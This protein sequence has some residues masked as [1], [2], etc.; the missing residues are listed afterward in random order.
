ML[1]VDGGGEETVTLTRAD[2]L[3]VYQ[4]GINRWRAGRDNDGG[5]VLFEVGTP[6]IFLS[7]GICDD[8]SFERAVLDFYPTI[9]C[10][11]YDPISD[12]GAVKHPRLRFHQENVPLPG[13]IAAGKN[14]LVKLDIEGDE[15]PW[16]WSLA[17]PDAIA[18]LV[19]ELHSPHLER[20]NWDVLRDLTK[21]HALVHFHANN[22]DGIVDIDGV[23]VPGTMETTW[24]RRDLAGNLEPNREPI[25]GFLD[26]PNDKSKPD[27][28]IDW[29]P[30]FG[31]TP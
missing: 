13:E 8:N 15:W 3:R 19:V 11:A 27:H 30:F 4:C 9:E 24:V 25:P 2:F 31:W 16:L 29:A 22:W 10:D 12:G 23:R 17:F 1:G 20:W 21:T 14:M 7:G 26:M 5:Y 6:D 28:V 18:Q